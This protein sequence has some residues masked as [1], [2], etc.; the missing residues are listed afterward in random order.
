MS[1]A[2]QVYYLNLLSP[3]RIVPYIIQIHLYVDGY[4]FFTLVLLNVLSVGIILFFYLLL[5]LLSTSI[6]KVMRKYFLI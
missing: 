4:F 3:L 2:F 1:C 6:T 5:L